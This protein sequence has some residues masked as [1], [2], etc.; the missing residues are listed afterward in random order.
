M[1]IQLYAFFFQSGAVERWESTYRK[2]GFLD[3]TAT[4]EGRKNKTLEYFEEARALYLSHHVYDQLTHVDLNMGFAYERSQQLPEACK[5]FDRAL[6]D[7]K[8]NV[9]ANPGAKR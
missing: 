5:A 9:E 3:K 2:Q 7:Y 8:T 4:F 6:E 1:P